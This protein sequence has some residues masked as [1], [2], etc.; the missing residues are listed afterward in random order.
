MGTFICTGGN[1]Q[2]ASLGA[3]VGIDYCAVTSNGGSINITGN[4]I[5]GNLWGSIGA[6]TGDSITVSGDVTIGAFKGSF[7]GVVDIGGNLQVGVSSTG[8]VDPYTTS[9]DVGGNLIFTGAMTGEIF[10]CLITNITGD[11]VFQENVAVVVG[12]GASETGGVLNCANLTALKDVTTLCSDGGVLTASG[13]ISLKN[14]TDVADSGFGPC[15]ISADTITVSGTCAKVCNSGSVVMTCNL[16]SVPNGCDAFGEV[17]LTGSADLGPTLTWDSSVTV[18]GDL[19]LRGNQGGS[20][21]I[22]EIT[23]TGKTYLTGGTVVMS[24][25]AFVCSDIYCDVDT[26]LQ[27]WSETLS[28]NCPNLVKPNPALVRPSGNIGSFM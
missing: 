20:Y 5:V 17:Q 26:V 1:C 8:L 28:G 16:L 22:G 23:V 19:T 3:G 27:I 21:R 25:D 18:S 15:T 4:L 11:V 24:P 13:A 9:L 10:S 6:D 12:D 2:I 7:A 14:V